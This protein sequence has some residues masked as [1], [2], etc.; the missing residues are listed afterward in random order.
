[1]AFVTAEETVPGMADSIEARR[2]TLGIAKGELA[3]L[4]GRSRET[5][6]PVLAGLRRRYDD[7]TIF[8]LGRVLRWENDWYERLQAGEAP[9]EI[10][11]DDDRLAVI[12]QRLTR[13]EEAVQQ[14]LDDEPRAR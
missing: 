12:E 1:M 8:G 6:R 4:A 10:P 14:L 9:T 13:V 11:V 3:A 2:R 7:A 5:L